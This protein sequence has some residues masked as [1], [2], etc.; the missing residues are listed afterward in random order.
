[1]CFSVHKK[2]C[3]GKAVYVCGDTKELGLWKPSMSFKLK[4]NEVRGV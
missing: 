3:Y 2:V 4:W 1:M